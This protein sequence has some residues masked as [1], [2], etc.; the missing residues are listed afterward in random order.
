[1]PLTIAQ[2]APM[3]DRDPYLYETLIKLVQEINVTQKQTGVAG[4]SA[5]A[6]PPAPGAITVVAANGFFDV[7]VTDKSSVQRGIQ[8]FA[9]FDTSPN[10]QNAHTLPMG[11]SRNAHVAL[12]NLTTYWRAYSMYVGSETRSD[13]AYFGSAAN[14]TGVAGGGAAGPA[15]QATQGSGTSQIPG[16]GF[17]GRTPIKSVL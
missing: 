5:L 11:P 17:G 1:M 7:A 6:A 4:S 14:P 8:Y 2:L 10:F 16:Y 3:K 12:G 9:E 15:L 13:Y